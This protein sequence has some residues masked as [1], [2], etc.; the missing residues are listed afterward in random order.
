M[1]S[2]MILIALATVTLSAG[3]QQPSS[4]DAAATLQIKAPPKG[5]SKAKIDISC[6]SNTYTIST[7]SNSGSC[8]AHQGGGTCTDGNNTANVKCGHG[9]AT[10]TG[11]GSC[12]GK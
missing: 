2:I 3:C 7:G 6:G 10:S 11:S 8:F 9:C 4:E 1:R 12:T 5:P